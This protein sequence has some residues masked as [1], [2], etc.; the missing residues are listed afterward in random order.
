MTLDK[1]KSIFFTIDEFNTIIPTPI[2]SVQFFC[3]CNVFKRETF[4]RNNEFYL[5]N[6]CVERDYYLNNYKFF[7]V[8]NTNKHYYYLTDLN[9]KIIHH[10]EIYDLENENSLLDTFILNNILIK[11]IGYVPKYFFSCEM[12][13]IYRKI[14]K[15]IK[16]NLYRLNKRFSKR[17]ARIAKNEKNINLEFIKYKNYDLFNNIISSCIIF[18]IKLDTKEF[19]IGN[20]SYKLQEINLN[21]IVL[22][23]NYNFKLSSENIKINKILPKENI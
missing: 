13:N 18:L 3:S 16:N 9:K 10:N 4:S 22:N 11:L 7:I 21:N 2:L 19:T 8:Y 12:N 20:F 15:F 1:S 23:D 14:N 17:I 5:V 6:C